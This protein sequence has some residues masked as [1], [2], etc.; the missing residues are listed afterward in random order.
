MVMVGGTIGGVVAKEVVR[1][2]GSH[3]SSNFGD[4]AS[5]ANVAA[6][7]QG[8]LL[9]LQFVLE[10]TDMQPLGDDSSLQ[11]RR[12]YEKYY[13]AGVK[14]LETHRPGVLEDHDKIISQQLKGSNFFKKIGR[15]LKLMYACFVG[16]N[17]KHLSPSIADTMEGYAD[18]AEKFL[19]AATNK[20]IRRDTFRCPLVT[21]LF[22]GKPVRY[23]GDIGRSRHVYFL[24]L[25]M[26][27]GGGC[28]VA[29]VR[30][31]YHD[32]V[33]V[34]ESFQLDTI[35]RL[36]E[37]TDIVATAIECLQSAASLHKLPLR[38][39]VKGNINQLP[40]LIQGIPDSEG[41]RFPSVRK[42]EISKWIK[43]FRADPLCCQQNSKTAIASELS[44][45]LPEQI[46]FFSLSCYFRPS[47]EAA[48]RT[49]NAMAD[50]TPPLELTINLVPH[51]EFT[52][53]K[54]IT[55]ARRMGSSELQSYD[56][57]ASSIQGTVDEV[58]SEA[59]DCIIHRPEVTRY[60]LL[61]FCKHGFS[62]LI[63]KKHVYSGSVRLAL[64]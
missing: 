2:V 36:S 30:Y 15:L 41:P 29:L 47:N 60:E 24:A 5:K 52:V 58:Q 34:D 46:Y 43:Y 11:Q 44:C 14:L 35:L 23:R 49:G 25:P 56:G 64:L 8:A 48:D 13:I 3:A 19:D 1:A 22:D 57:E 39:S 16:S 53:V 37:S 21:Q 63:A 7:I 4:H 20:Y 27:L 6:R 38:D 51:C 54:K 62:T 55:I 26:I 10:K 31:A 9:R 45:I 12:W 59:F 33:R 40:D 42:T 61:W 32:T 18:A 17:H 28:L 50:R